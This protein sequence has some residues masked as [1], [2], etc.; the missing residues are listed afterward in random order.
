MAISALKVKCSPGLDKVE[1]RIIQNFLV[2]FD[3]KSS[4]GKFRLISLASCMLNLM[5]KLIHSRL[6]FF[7]E[8]Y[9]ILSNSQFGFRKGLSCT[10]NLAI[11]AT[12]I[13]SSFVAGD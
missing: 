4:P 5:E 6:N 13:W 8:S 9:N 3:P 12:E 2:M 1:N 10:D 11:L 7:L